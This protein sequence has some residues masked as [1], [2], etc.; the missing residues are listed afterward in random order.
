[1]L[2]AT[3]THLG[4]YSRQAGVKIQALE[5]EL[6]AREQRLFTLSATAEDYEL[7]VKKKTADLAEVRSQLAAAQADGSTLRNRLESQAR[8]LEDSDSRV[9]SANKEYERMKATLARTEKELDSLR[10]LM[11]ARR[12]EEV[13]RAEAESSREKEL[14]TLREQMTKV[15]Q[16]N[17]SE[18]DRARK[19]M[20]DIEAKYDIATTELQSMKDAKAKSEAALQELAQKLEGQQALFRSAEAVKRGL[21]SDLADTRKRLIE[22]QAALAE[23]NSSR[24]VSSER[25]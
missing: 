3:G 2:S 6:K 19:A 22:Q 8:Q 14:L 13:Q 25:P 5:S 16:H 7:M 24:S 23:L 10:S 18:L 21:D 4:H 15:S 11:A 17:A 9:A 12:S 20:S 1:M